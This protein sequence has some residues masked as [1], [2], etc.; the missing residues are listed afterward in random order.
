M[1]TLHTPDGHPLRQRDGEPFR[2]T[3]HDLARAGQRI[4][5]HATKQRLTIRFPR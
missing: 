5:G 1:Y 3:T 4:L 2:Y